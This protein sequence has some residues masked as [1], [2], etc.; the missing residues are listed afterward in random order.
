MS[1]I[2]NSLEEERD[3]SVK[4]AN[5]YLSGLSL[6]E[7]ASR[8]NLS[9]ITVRRY[10]KEKLP[11]YVPS[12]AAKVENKMDSN[13]P[14]SIQDETITKRVLESYFMLVNEG[15]T[16]SEIA[17]EKGVGL[18]VTTRDLTKRLIMLHDVAPEVV[19]KQMLEKAAEVLKKHSYENLKLGAALSTENQERS[20]DGRFK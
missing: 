1:S 18:M 8:V 4:I 16:L 12:L 20:E 14:K 3:F 17:S 5:M 15:K 2:F 19:T 6:R 7:I 10:L 11:L 9:H 13:I